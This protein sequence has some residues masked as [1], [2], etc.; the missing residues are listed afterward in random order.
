LIRWFALAGGALLIALAFFAATNVADTRQG[1]IAEVVTLLSGLAG[2]ALLLYGLIPGRAHTARENPR[3][4]P[5]VPVHRVRSANDLLTGAGGLL[6]AA[7]MVGGLAISGG[8]LWALLG[9]LL[10]LPMVAGC[11]YL[12][13]AFLRDPR[14]EWKIDLH[15]LT[16]QR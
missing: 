1:L 2:T 13:A 8:W 9:L 16:G 14:R 3:P 10:L 4:S 6:L 5:S 15:R 12:C 7:V 11:V